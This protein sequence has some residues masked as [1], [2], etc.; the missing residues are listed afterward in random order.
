[1]TPD[2]LERFGRSTSDAL[3]GRW[4]WREL[5]DCLHALAAD[6]HSR[7]RASLLAATTQPDADTVARAQEGILER[8]R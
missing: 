1:M 8:W 7:F 3:A 5:E 2:L 6:P 4:P